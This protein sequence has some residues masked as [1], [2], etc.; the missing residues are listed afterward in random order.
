MQ[1][2]ALAPYRIDSYDLCVGFWFV[3][4][5]LS[6]A[7]CVTM[8]GRGAKRIQIVHTFYRCERGCLRSCVVKSDPRVTP[9]I[10]MHHRALPSRAAVVLIEMHRSFAL[11]VRN[12]R[13]SQ[14]Q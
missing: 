6:V 1:S 9:L 10:I 3:I 8:H 11:G 13:A 7:L 5:A 12:A 2:L 4:V 14:Q